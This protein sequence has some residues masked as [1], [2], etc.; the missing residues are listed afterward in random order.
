MIIILRSYNFFLIRNCQFLPYYSR[1]HNVPITLSFKRNCDQNILPRDQSIL[2]HSGAVLNLKNKSIF[3]S[4]SQTPNWSRKLCFTGMIVLPQLILS[5]LD[6]HRQAAVSG[7]GYASH[8]TM[9]RLL[10][11]AILRFQQPKT[12]T[13]RIIISKIKNKK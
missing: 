7:D 1:F 11:Q 13:Y 6:F 4:V 8:L 12:K 5:Q 9:P 2:S 3:Y 10:G